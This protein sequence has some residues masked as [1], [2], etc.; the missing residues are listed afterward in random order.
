L[1]DGHDPPC[2]RW[3]IARFDRVGTLR[4][5]HPTRMRYFRRT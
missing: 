4:F 1:I 2:P 5:A 3:P